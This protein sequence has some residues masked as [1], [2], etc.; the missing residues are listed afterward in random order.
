MME[1]GGSYVCDD[2]GLLY[3]TAMLTVTAYTRLMFGTPP[4]GRVVYYIYI[5]SASCEVKSAT[6]R[7]EGGITT[8]VIMNLHP[9]VRLLG[10]WFEGIPGVVQ[11]TEDAVSNHPLLHCSIFNIELQNK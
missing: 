3:S 10:L 2:K 1:E 5:I 6:D 7:M 11:S 4:T 9:L 8:L